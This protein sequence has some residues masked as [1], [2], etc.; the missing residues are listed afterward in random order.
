MN[1]FMGLSLICLVFTAAQAESDQSEFKGS[2][3]FLRM[4]QD[5][6]GPINVEWE[7]KECDTNGVVWHRKNQGVIVDGEY[8][9]IKGKDVKNTLKKSFSELEDKDEELT[10]DQEKFLEKQHKIKRRK[11]ERELFSKSFSKYHKDNPKTENG[12]WEVLLFPFGNN[13]HEK[14]KYED[15]SRKNSKISNPCTIK[16]NLIGRSR[17]SFCNPIE[18]VF[19]KIFGSKKDSNRKRNQKFKV[20]RDLPV[21]DHGRDVQMHRP[22]KHHSLEKMKNRNSDIEFEDFERQ[23]QMMWKQMRELEQAFFGDFD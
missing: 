8:K 14:V 7:G 3:W 19:E 18:R 16:D 6:D 23:Y 20:Q 13:H 1:R 17:I 5:N 2:S 4:S 15:F 21:F 10:A 22:K 9:P 11:G 12:L